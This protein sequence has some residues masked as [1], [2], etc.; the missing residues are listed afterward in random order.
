MNK[1]YNFILELKEEGEITQNESIEFPRRESKNVDESNFEIEE[2]LAENKRDRDLVENFETF[3]KN[4]CVH[5]DPKKRKRD[6]LEYSNK[7]G[8]IV[9]ENEILY[10]NSYESINTLD[11]YD[12]KSNYSNEGLFKCFY[13]I[14]TM[15]KNTCTEIFYGGAKFYEVGK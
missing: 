13:E 9:Y 14:S 5:I 12:Y 7:M 3:L 1:F 15:E 11:L 8:S 4:E 10:F 2:K 6:K